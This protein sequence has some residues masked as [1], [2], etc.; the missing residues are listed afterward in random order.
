MSSMRNK[1]CPCQS[2]RK[3]K[4]CCGSEAALSEQRRNQQEAELAAM[5]ARAE[6]RERREAMIRENDRLSRFSRGPVFLYVLSAALAGG[7][8]RR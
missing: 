7:N 8:Y 6:E 1:S 3:F 5:R 2:G 4:R